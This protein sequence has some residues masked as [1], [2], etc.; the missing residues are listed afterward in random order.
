MKSLLQIISIIAAILLGFVIF[1]GEQS[2]TLITKVGYWL[3]LGTFI[4]L[5]FNGYRATKDSNTLDTLKRSPFA[6]ASIAIA[7]F[8]ALY[9]FTREGP[10]FK[11]AMD[12]PTLANSAL[13]MHKSRTYETFE[14]SIGQHATPL[15][16]VDKRPLFFPFLVSII[17]DATNYWKEAPFY[18]NLIL[19]T[20]IILLLFHFCQDLTKNLK[21]S[22]IAT[23]FVSF[24]PLFVQT[25]SSAGFDTLNAF[26][27]L[28]LLWNACQFYKNPSTINRDLLLLN[29]IALANTRYESA[30]FVIST[31]ILVVFVSIKGKAFDVT[32]TSILAPLLLLTIPWQKRYIDSSSFFKNE[33]GNKEHV[34]SSEYLATNLKSAYNYFFS[35]DQNIATT[36]FLALAT[37]IASIICISLILKKKKPIPG[38]LAPSLLIGGT[39]VS[40]FSLLMFYFWGTLDDEAASRL[41]LPLIL[42]GAI[43][44][45]I[46][47]NELS[48]RKK[49]FSIL[50]PIIL[51]CSVAYSIP[52]INQARYSEK[53]LLTH[54][55]EWAFSVLENELD[56][57]DLI[58]SGLSRFWSLDQ[59]PAISHYR[60]TTG[61]IE[62][63]N[64]LLTSQYDQVFVIQHLNFPESQN[65]FPLTLNYGNDLGPAFILE[66]I[67]SLSL[68][69]N[70]LTRISR[71]KE[72][73]AEQVNTQPKYDNYIR[74]YAKG[75]FTPIVSYASSKDEQ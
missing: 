44:V 15:T 18:L 17:H 59:I 52:T 68:L 37:T 6:K 24:H 19:S 48:S 27:I 49:N 25:S 56:E 22:A 2:K 39:V 60:A 3:M 12:E 54:R 55:Y 21:A 13:S 73:K 26:L 71:L 51:A 53:N 38:Y 33:L 67:A 46:G 45:A 69:P 5:V 75:K 10:S 31:G 23:A 41:A 50:F 8:I 40:T 43:V 70:N 29:T 34:F 30:L 47:Y 74:K 65:E 4:L 1:D 72:I 64:S 61:L 66:E 28:F 14:A 20:G 35:F 9:A 11:I 36:P 63:F 7:F 16:F 57:R 62:L 32:L 42:V 58:I